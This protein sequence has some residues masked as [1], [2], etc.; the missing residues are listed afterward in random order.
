MKTTPLLSKSQDCTRASWQA[1]SCFY[2]GLGLGTDTAQHNLSRSFENKNLPL[3]LALWTD[4]YYGL[5][6]R[7]LYKIYTLRRGRLA[8]SLET[9]KYKEIFEKMERL[10]IEFTQLGTAQ[11]QQI[12]IY[13]DIIVNI[14]DVTNRMTEIRDIDSIIRNIL[15]FIQIWL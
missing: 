6:S 10:W 12:M 2:S 14:K 7:P 8:H 1:V 9:N 5:I 13:S 4:F 11:P 3:G 15:I